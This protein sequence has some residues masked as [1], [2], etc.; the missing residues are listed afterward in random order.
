MPKKW[1]RVFVTANEIRP[2]WHVRMQ[3]AFQE[4]N[5]SAISKTVN[6]ANAAT[7]ADVE[8]IYRLAYSLD[9]KGVTVYRDGSREMQVLS[10]LDG[11]QGAGRSHQVGQAPRPAPISGRCSTPPPP[12]SG[13][14]GGGHR[15]RAGHHGR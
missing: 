6:F 1:Q 3:A 4:Y 8:E 2:E 11:D 14:P 12:A 7:E 9:C 5:D 15:R 13:E 10:T